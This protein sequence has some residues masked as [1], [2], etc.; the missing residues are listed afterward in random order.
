MPYRIFL[1]HV[2]E[3]RELAFQIKEVIEHSFLRAVSVFVSSHQDNVRTGDDWF[4]EIE[5]Q[6]KRSDTVLL[7]LTSLSTVRPWVNFEAGA[8]WFLKKH[9]VPLC[10]GN[11]TIDNLPPPFNQKQATDLSNGE[12]ITRLIQEIARREELKAP[13]C[14]VNALI[15]ASTNLAKKGPVILPVIAQQ[16]TPEQPE[17]EYLPSYGDSAELFSERLADAFPGLSGIEEFVGES[18]VNRLEVLLREPLCRRPQDLRFPELRDCPFWWVRGMS[19][20]FIR[21]FRRLG[22]EQIQ[23]DRDELRISRIVAVR[24]FWLPYM[25]FVYVEILPEKPIGIY[26]YHNEKWIQENLQ[27]SLRRGWGYYVSEEYALWKNKVISRGE[28]DDGSAIVEGKPIRI[29]GAEPRRRYLTPYNFILCG[30]FH[31]L[32]NPQFD[33]ETTGLFDHILQKRATVTELIEC[34]EKLRDTEEFQKTLVRRELEL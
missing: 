13:T 33:S 7:L 28:F 4:K 10:A 11:L 12:S 22:A 26:N 25:D 3:E 21:F 16:S 30:R 27:E 32:N 31:I 2:H 19:N 23:I 20:M 8:A 6:L 17:V 1:S 9:L 14:D 34:V 24:K 5:T 29:D 15:E 18:A